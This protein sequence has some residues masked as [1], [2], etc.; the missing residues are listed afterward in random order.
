METL[1]KQDLIINYLQK[2]YL[3]YKLSEVGCNSIIKDILC[4]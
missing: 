3:K 2:T 1:G 4:K